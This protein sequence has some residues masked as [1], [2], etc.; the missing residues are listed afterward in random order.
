MVV[1]R[2]KALETYRSPAASFMTS[3]EHSLC[4]R[5]DHGSWRKRSGT[6]SSSEAARFHNRSA[7]HGHRT[8]REGSGTG[9]VIAPAGS[10]ANMTDAGDRFYRLFSMN[11]A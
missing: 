10:V 8:V 11:C 3:W 2:A 9:A 7:A 4:G 1:T 6:S 5:G